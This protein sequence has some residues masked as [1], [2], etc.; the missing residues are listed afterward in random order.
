MSGYSFWVIRVALRTFGLFVSLCAC[1][2]IKLA[3]TDACRTIKL[4]LTDARSL[5][6]DP[7]LCTAQGGMPEGEA[8]VPSSGA[9]LS[10]ARGVINPATTL[11]QS[12][13]GRVAPVDRTRLVSPL[14]APGLS[15][16]AR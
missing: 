9:R 8:S 10:H 5:C 13:G 4:A 1:R 2:T 16:R 14:C 7:Q 3:L 12:L 15:S 6:I 11:S